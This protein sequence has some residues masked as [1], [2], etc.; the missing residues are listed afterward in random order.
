MKKLIVVLLASVVLVLSSCAM[1][2]TVQSEMPPSQYAAGRNTNFE[3]LG[4]VKVVVNGKGAVVQDSNFKQVDK[5]ITGDSW[6]EILL[7]KAKQSYPNAQ[8]VIDIERSY[9]GKSG[10]L[11]N[12]SYQVYTGLVIRYR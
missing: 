12:S 9:L 1:T 7:N 11:R 5:N 4:L 10:F 3:V 6:R 2:K 8:N